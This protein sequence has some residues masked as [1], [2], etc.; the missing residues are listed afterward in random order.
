MNLA[1]MS[2]EKQRSAI[3]TVVLVISTLL[4]LAVVQ[5]SAVPLLA[6]SLAAVGMA[7]GAILIGTA[8]KGV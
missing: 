5:S 3:G 6:G 2:G 8:T 7:V 4:I 1:R